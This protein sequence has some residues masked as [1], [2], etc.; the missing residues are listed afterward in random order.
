MSLID[1]T[2]LTFSYEGS[3]QV[4][5]Q[6]VSLQLDTRWRLGLIGRN[7]R[8]KTT[9]LRLLMGELPYG[10]SISSN[11][12]FD[13]FPYTVPDQW[14]TPQQLMEELAPQAQLWQ[15]R[16][17]LNLLQMDPEEMLYRPFGTLSGGEQ[18]KVLLALLF[19]QEG[20]F[21][22]L[23]EPTNHLDEQARRSV[24]RY[25]G[26]KEGFLLVSHDRKLLDACVDHILSI[27][28]TELQLQRGNFSSW[29]QNKQAQDHLEEQEHEK[30]QKEVKRLAQAAKQTADWSQQAEQ[31][32]YAS[33]NSGLRPDR[34]YVGHRAAKVMKRAM[35]IGA[36]RQEALE[37][38]ATLLK[39]V[40]RAE[41]LKLFWEPYRSHQLLQLTDV[42][43]Q[44]GD[45][46]VCPPIRLTLNQGERVAITGPNGCGKSS[47]LK[48][49]AGQEI[50]HQGMLVQG[51][52]LKISYVPQDVSHLQGNLRDF[53]QKEGL[54]ESQL[55]T[56]LRKLDFSRPQLEQDMAH[57]SLGQK[58]KV[59]LA[60]SLCQRAHLYVWDEPLNYVD[61]FSR[62]QLEELIL[63]YGPA[64]LFVEHDG[65]FRERIATRELSLVPAGDVCPKLRDQHP[66]V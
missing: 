33:R 16:R 54:E 41:P 47:L 3:D 21:L 49:L 63:A 2:H 24:A 1:I 31:G 13:Y 57:M 53:A 66:L 32:K 42:C 22:L 26:Q 18:T 9:L 59:L 46:P 36:R 29:Y 25:L 8:G 56:I 44:Y 23:D 10:G 35:A 14:M 12:T 5:F 6:D 27:N 64:M 58:K 34:G 39:N 11:V 7:G 20:H 52:D 4:L 40:E 60:A 30:L 15:L 19:L 62:L 61:L 43:I 17:E 45:R 37:Q 65:A 38:K 48:L 55:K 28:R 51:A 50:P